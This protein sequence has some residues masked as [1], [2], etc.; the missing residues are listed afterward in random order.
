MSNA[1]QALAEACAIVG[2][3]SA[4]AAGVGVS[5]SMVNQWLKG[6][7][8]IPA[9]KCAAIE[10]VTEGKVTVDRLSSAKWL[11]VRDRAWPHTAGR[12]LL[13]VAGKSPA[14]AA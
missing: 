6:E 4:L 9:D 13:D 11:R 12:P 5:P 2:S 1:T 7:R 3:Q 10:R 14:E 8:P